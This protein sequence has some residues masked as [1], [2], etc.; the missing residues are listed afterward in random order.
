MAESR[1]NPLALLELPRGLTPAELAGGFR[2]PDAG[3]LSPQIEQSFLRRSAS[4]SAASQQLLL[5]A[6]AEP[7]GRRDPAVAGCRAARDRGRGGRRPGRRG[8]VE[9]GPRVRFRHPLVRSAVYRAAAVEDRQRAHRALAEA[10]DP[11][12]DPDRRAWHRAYAAPGLDEAVAGDL[13]RSAARA[14]RRGGVAAEAAFLERAAELTPV[15]HR[16]AE[17]TLAAA[18][19]KLEAGAPDA[20]NALLDA[21]ALVPLDDLQ[22]ALVRRTRAEVAFTVRRGSDVAALLLDAAR[23]LVGLDARQARK[24]CLEA[25]GAA[26]HAG[27]VVDRRTVLEIVRGAPA[28][29][30]P[31][32]DDLLLDGLATRVVEGFVAGAPPLRAAMEA[33]RGDDGGDGEVDRWLWLA[34]RAAADLWD[35]ETWSELAHRAVRLARQ[36]ARSTCCPSPRPTW[37]ARTCTAASTARRRR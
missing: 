10:T 31:R 9:V 13:E 27:D 18:Q 36:P 20:A 7:R 21:A 37:P 34:C 30:A 2:V 11:E 12:A 6:A 16:R 1:G 33:F 35:I 28:P 5:L 3:S 25:L 29:P 4:S 15:P 17:R 19:A 22:R 24:T 26:L 23:G 8:L 14:R 32:P